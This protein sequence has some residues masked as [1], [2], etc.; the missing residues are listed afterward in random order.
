LHPFASKTDTCDERFAYG[1][2][3]GVT[4]ADDDNFSNDTVFNLCEV[5]H[6]AN[7]KLPAESHA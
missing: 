3:R 6:Y 1:L 7:V 2:C 4:V 5:C